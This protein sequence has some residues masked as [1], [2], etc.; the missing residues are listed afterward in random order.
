MRRPY[1]PFPS[2]PFPSPFPYPPHARPQLHHAPD[3][4]AYALLCSDRAEYYRDVESFVMG[5]VV[6]LAAGMLLLIAPQQIGRLRFDANRRFAGLSSSF[7]D[8]EQRENTNGRNNAVLSTGLL[9]PSVDTSGSDSDR[10]TLVSP[11]RNG[12]QI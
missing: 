8:S 12:Q 9:A 4:Y 1:F 5:V 3:S 2:F 7:S 11:E 10:Q 6:V